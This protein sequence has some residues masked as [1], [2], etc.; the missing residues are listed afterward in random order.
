MSMTVEA[1]L[2]C[3]VP[4]GKAELVR[5]ELRVTPPPGAPHGTAA[6]NLVVMSANSVR[7]HGLGRVFADSFDGIAGDTPG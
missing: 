3:S 7:A 6:T 4:E 5:G 2:T 1:F